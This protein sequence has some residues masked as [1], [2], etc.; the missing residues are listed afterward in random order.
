MN[1]K[2]IEV[3]AQYPIHFHGAIGMYNTL[4]EIITMV[5]SEDYMTID[6]ALHKEY[7]D[8]Y[9]QLGLC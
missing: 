5:N 2:N 7:G 9:E 8:E 6:K 4:T 3:N 1:N